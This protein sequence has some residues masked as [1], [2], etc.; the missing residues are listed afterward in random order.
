MFLV[1]HREVIMIYGFSAKTNSFY[2]MD[3]EADY[4]KNGS[5]PDDVKPVSDEVWAKY[6]VQPPSGKARGADEQGLPCWADAPEPDKHSLYEMALQK[7]S[8]LLSEADREIRML[9]VVFDVGELTREEKNNLM[10]WKTYLA[11][12][13][14]IDPHDAPNISWPVEVTENLT[15]D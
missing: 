11:A 9:N 5:W 7:K 10:K 15:E 3:S 12:L 14:R 2:L 6:C 8:Y 4:R 1:E 13:Y